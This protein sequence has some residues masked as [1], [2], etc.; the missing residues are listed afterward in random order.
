MLSTVADRLRTLPPVVVYE[1]EYVCRPESELIDRDNHEVEIHREGSTYVVEADW[2]W[3]LV[4]SV[5]FEDRDSLRY[6]SA[7]AAHERRDRPSRGG[8]LRRR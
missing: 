7:R 8:G 2:L 4:G 5:N 6:F 3:N 1:P